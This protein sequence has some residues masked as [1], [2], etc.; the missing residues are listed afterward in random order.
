MQ[1]VSR[2][3]LCKDG[4]GSAVVSFVACHATTNADIEVVV[5]GRTIG[6][7]LHLNLAQNH[8]EDVENA[9]HRVALPMFQDATALALDV[10]DDVFVIITSRGCGGVQTMRHTLRVRDGGVKC[11]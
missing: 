7:A 8:S 5:A 10:A 4:H 2:A 1:P 11:V 3:T 6:H 9:V